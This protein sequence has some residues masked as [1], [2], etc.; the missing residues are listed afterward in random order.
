MTSVSGSVKNTSSGRTT[1][2]ASPSS[3]ADTTSVPTLSKRRPL[4]TW[5]ATH[6]PKAVMAQWRRKGVRLAS[7]LF[8]QNLLG[9]AVGRLKGLGQ[10]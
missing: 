8:S 4:N 2:L 3:K 9:G 6:R 5:L 1:A 10:R 7:M